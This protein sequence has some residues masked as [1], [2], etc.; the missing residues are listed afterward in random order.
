MLQYIRAISIATVILA[1]VLPAAAYDANRQTDPQSP[2]LAINESDLE[3]QALATIAKNERQ[4]RKWHRAIVRYRGA[5][6]RIE[7]QQAEGQPEERIMIPF[8]DI[9]GV[10]NL[11]KSQSPENKRFIRELIRRNIDLEA[12]LESGAIPEQ[13]A[14]YMDEVVVVGNI[15]DHIPIDPAEFSADDVRKMRGQRANAN[16]LYRDGYYDEAYPILLNLA[17]RG[18]KDSQSRLAYI[19]FNGTDNVEKSNLRALGWLSAAA[20]GQTDP[21]FR[22]LFRRYMRQI[23]DDLRPTVDAVVDGYRNAY[24]SSKYVDC[25]RNHFSHSGIVK[26]TICRFDF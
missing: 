25:T 6:T 16:E 26:R 3:I 8:R 22:V 24:A 15:F 14:D 10:T 5:M 11:L 1:F 19:L 23:P 4:A 17:K 21:M 18:F 20:H 7:A 2:L 9:V 13:Y 12:Y